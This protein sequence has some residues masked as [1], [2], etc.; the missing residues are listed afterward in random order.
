MRA[1]HIAQWR[2]KCSSSSL[3]SMRCRPSRRGSISP[4]H[5]RSPSC[6]SAAAQATSPTAQAAAAPLGAAEPTADGP[7]RELVKLRWG[8]VPSWSKEP[9]GGNPLINAH[10]ETVATKPAFRAA[11]RQRRCLIPADGFYEWKKIG[12]SKQPYFIHRPD[13]RPFAIAGLWER[14][15]DPEGRPLETCT[16]LTTAANAVLRP[17]HERMPVIVEPADYA[18]WLDRS[19]TDP[20]ALRPLFAALT[21]EE[22]V[23]APFRRA[24]TARLTTTRNA[25]CRPISRPRPIRVCCGIERR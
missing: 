24:S 23:F 13:D 25:S 11:M 18:Q 3:R 21:A 1:I 10:S 16:I 17:L 19:A 7:S 14:W 8:L 15:T 22:F 6:G 4:P 9:S 5:N 2:R 12:P 20:E